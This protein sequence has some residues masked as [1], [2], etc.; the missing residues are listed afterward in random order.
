MNITIFPGQTLWDALQKNNTVL[1]RPCGGKGI[2]GGCKVHVSGVGDVV[3]CRFMRPGSYEVTLPAQTN[4]ST[5]FESP[6]SPILAQEL[7]KPASCCAMVDIGTTTVAV[8][9][10]DGSQ[11]HRH[12]FTNPQ[13]AFGADVM[14]RIESANSGHLQ[15]L[16]DMIRQPLIELIATLPSCPV[17]IS[18]NTTMLHLLRGFSCEGLGKAPF[19][20]ISL[21]F[22]TEQWHCQGKIYDILFLPSI[23]AYVGADIVSGIFHLG[24][25]EQETPTLLI[26]LGT[27]GEMAIGNS[28][29]L[30]CTSAAAGPAFEGSRLGLSLHAS[31]IMQ[32]LH[33]MLDSGVMDETGLLAK[34]Y[35]EKGFPIPSSIL[36]KANITEPFYFTQEDVRDIQLAKGAIRAGIDILLKESKILPHE[37]GAVYLA[38]GMGYFLDASDAVAIGLLPESLGDKTQSVGNTSLLGALKF[39]CETPAH[40]PCTSSLKSAIID[41]SAFHTIAHIPESA[42]EIILADHPE[43]ADRYVGAMNFGI[44]PEE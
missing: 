4:F 35:F 21:A 8:L 10:Y 27:N 26:D 6:S 5:V 13:R 17:F 33:M 34:P 3:S 39:A 11:F 2:C 32:C 12:H 41:S 9:L 16:S 7:M 1:P 30:L 44:E 23:S 37:L 15:E 19:H 14:S 31:G 42:S 28:H 20:P 29:G 22:E 40:L 43:F 38:G 36:K 24:M 18:A 25:A